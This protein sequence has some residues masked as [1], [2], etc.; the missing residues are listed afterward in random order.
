[1]RPANDVP[2]VFLCKAPV[3]FR[4]GILGDFPITSSMDAK[5]DDH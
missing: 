4:K 3:D 1:M 2:E 5:P